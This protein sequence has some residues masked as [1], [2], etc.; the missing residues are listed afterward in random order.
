MFPDRDVIASY[1]P[2]TRELSTQGFGNYYGMVATETPDGDF[3]WGAV[4]A[5][6][7]ATTPE[8]EA[9]GTRYTELVSKTQHVS[10]GAASVALESNDG[11]IALEYRRVVHP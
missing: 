6:A 11:T 8:L 3:T 2:N 9:A 10:T 7:M 4:M 5:T 1:D